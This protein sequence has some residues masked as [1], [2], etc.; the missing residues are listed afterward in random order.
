[1]AVGG[2][3]CNLHSRTR[4]AGKTIQ[5]R[6]AAA[7]ACCPGTTRCRRRWLATR[8]SWALGSSTC[9]RGAGGESRTTSGTSSP[10]S[11]RSA[12]S[13]CVSTLVPGSRAG[14]SRRGCSYHSWTGSGPWGASGVGPG[15]ELRKVDLWTRP[16]VSRLRSE[17]PSALRSSEG[18]FRPRGTET[19]TAKICTRP[20]RDVVD[21]GL[22]A[23]TCQSDRREIKPPCHLWKPL[24]HLL[25]RLSWTLL[26]HD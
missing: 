9:R 20:N 12:D 11:W 19:L 16:P 22:G 23:R 8:V 14:T 1:M 25:H 4:G 26:L 6:A 3:F 5:P 15:A 7:F 21:E 13:E 17:P 18:L 2:E 24:P 10:G